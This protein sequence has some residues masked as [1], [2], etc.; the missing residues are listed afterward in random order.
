M[1]PVGWRVRSTG[2]KG[3]EKR[4]SGGREETPSTGS[5]LE[6]GVDDALAQYVSTELYLDI[7]GAQVGKGDWNAD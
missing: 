6:P 2:L 3:L 4:G 5:G 1:S 7:V